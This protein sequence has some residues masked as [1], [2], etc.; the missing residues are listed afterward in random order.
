MRRSGYD[1]WITSVAVLS[2]TYTLGDWTGDVIL[3]VV[4]LHDASRSD[5]TATDTRLVYLVRHQQS[6]RVK[7]DRAQ[8]AVL[9]LWNSET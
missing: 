1:T 2:I 6:L 9:W 3:S 5:L 4:F 8:A 7:H